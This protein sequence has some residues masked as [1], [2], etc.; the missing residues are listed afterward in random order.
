MRGF[1]Y[2]KNG[3]LVPAFDQIQYP[4][5]TY[6]VYFL[7]N[8]I[9]ISEPVPLFDPNFIF[10][11]NFKSGNYVKIGRKNAKFIYKKFDHTDFDLNTFEIVK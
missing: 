4:K 11:Q 3:V 2:L 6:L 10:S 8:N 1:G 7:E 5:G 9:I